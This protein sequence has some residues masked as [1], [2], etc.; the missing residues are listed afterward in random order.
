VATTD[1]S[2]RNHR[3]EIIAAGVG[4]ALTISEESLG[5]L[6]FYILF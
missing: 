3:F 4:I 2:E 6:G 5:S 1:L